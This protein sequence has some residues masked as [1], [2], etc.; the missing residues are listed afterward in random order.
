MK[1]DINKSKNMINLSQEAY[2]DQLLKK[3]NMSDYRVANVP[4]EISVDLKSNL[5]QRDSKKGT[6]STTWYWYFDVSSSFN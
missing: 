1:V 3:F 6:L 5:N 2:V 4:L